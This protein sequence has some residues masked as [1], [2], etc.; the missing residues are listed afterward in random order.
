MRSL[1]KKEGV[2][3]VAKTL[4]AT[5]VIGVGTYG[6]EFPNVSTV[7]AYADTTTAT[8]NID[9][10]K[11]KI[12]TKLENYETDI[13]FTSSEYASL[14]I[15]SNTATDPKK[16]F[17][18]VLYEHP[19]IF[20][21]AQNV[22]GVAN[23]DGSGNKSFNLYAM[24]LYDNSDIDSKKVQINAK[25]ND[26]VNK[27]KSYGDLR[28]V[29]E[30]H[31]Y[32][33]SNIIY[34][35]EVA[36]STVPSSSINPNVDFN[37]YLADTRQITKD[38]ASF[39]EAHTL[40]G[41]LIKGDAV[42][43]GYAKIAK[44]LLNNS[45]IESDIIVSNTHAWN[46]VN[47]DGKYYQLDTTWD[48]QADEKTLSPYKYFNITTTE[49]GEDTSS[50]MT[51]HTATS[52]NV[53]N[54]T[55]STFDNIFR[56]VNGGIITGN[57]VVR[58]EDKLYGTELSGTTYNLYSSNL[59]GTNKTIIKSGMKIA[60]NAFA[61]KG[62]V[63]YFE[64]LSVSP[65]VVINRLNTTTNE[66]TQFI[67]LYT[68]MPP[69]G[70]FSY[71]FYVKDD[72]LSVT[73]TDNSGNTT[74]TYST[75]DANA[76]AL[77]LS[78]ATDAVVKAESSK[79]QV[80]VNSAK[81]LV[82]ILSDG[83][84]KSSLISRL[85]VVQADINAQ[86]LLLATD[87]VTKAEGSK[88][89]ADV[90]S[91][92][93]LVNALSSSADKTSLSQRLDTVQTAINTAKAIQ[94]ATD[95]VI[96][97]EGSK[98]QSDVDSAR[99]LVT[100][101]SSSTEKTDLTQRLDAVQTIIDSTAVIKVTGISVTGNDSISSKGGTVQL[102][103]TATPVN[104]TNKDVTWS[105]SD[106]NIATVD[107]TGIVTAIADGNVTITA[108]AKDNSGIT[109]TKSIAISGQ[110]TTTPV[111]DVKVT[112]ISIAGN[113]SI[114]SKGGTTTLTASILPTNANNKNVTWSSSNINVATVSSTGVVT[115]K[116]DGSVTITATATDGSGITGTKTITVSGQTTTPVTDIKLTG[117]SIG[118][119]NSISSKNGTTQLTATVTPTNANNQTVTWTSSNS[120][121]ATVSS[122][123][124]VTA[125]ADGNVTITATAKD[126]SNITGTKSITISGQTTT[127]PV[128]DV[129][130]TGININGSNSISSKGGTSQLTATVTPTNASN[131]AVTW[132]L[133]DT[134]I[135][136]VDSN[137]LVTAK[138][139]GSV[140][141]TATSTSKDSSG[142][143]STKIVTITG[144]TIQTTDSALKSVS[145]SGTEE[146]GRTLKSKIKY[147]G[148][149]PSIEYQWQRASSKSGDYS[150]I[151]GATD[152]TYKLKSSDKNKYVR[153]EVTATINGNTYTVYDT[154]GKIDT[155]SSNDSSSDSSSSS[156][157]DNSSPSSTSTN[158]STTS[159]SSQSYY[160]DKDKAKPLMPGA[161][162]TFTVSGQFVNPSGNPVSGWMASGG[163][164]Y[165]LDNNGVAKTGWVND[166]GNWYYLDPNVGY[167]RATMKIGWIKDN[168][169]WYY[170]NASGVMMA[171]TTID[172]YRLGSNGAL[173][174]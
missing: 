14:G 93:T 4:V 81:S 73:L 136:T 121:V 120:S 119:G 113:S 99:A 12:L 94:D 139:D 96:K 18:D 133:S 34:D 160:S 67:N 131:Q 111:T 132:T 42:C 10:I 9:I 108:T 27:Y 49:L 71:T 110:T 107:N 63:Y 5:S 57:N 171:N 114:T 48:D 13:T 104:A 15:V 150:D 158:N 50:N 1:N 125:I 122:S 65:Y 70:S 145:I 33:N 95:A 84:D 140:T 118:G 117:I 6:I 51:L 74:K 46:Y 98:V 62:Y 66:I 53:P 75:I 169:N 128:T 144:Q 82:D 168:G 25:L 143:S 7:I 130:V 87:A 22:V 41:A 123:G 17:F 124:L 129:K 112:G 142:V 26:I 100:L 52:G 58:F 83:S 77:A 21:V 156:S 146:E 32:I 40:Y 127:T 135:A 161:T 106:T 43:E 88:L 170:L 91:A 153:V 36:T 61:Y 2:K 154:T 116:T 174:G 44:I 134:S 31:D 159:A 165:Y 79:A 173:I 80:D 164:W 163:S 126:G 16:I 147:D 54:C 37:G 166:R 85:D 64:R 172:G 35:H 69:N 23:T 11:S 60:N 109:G 55:D 167:S 151:N 141:I 90:D 105:S 20:W 29:Y 138:A 24:N 102:T 45:G 8:S 89:Q 39:Y 148:T 3:L 19:E 162:T 30:I 76:E 72:V 149:K 38:N 155:A 28:K 115:A 59:D 47:I 92:R 86:A 103:A 68:D 101:L 157:T 97:A 137:G 78:Q 152:D 56:T